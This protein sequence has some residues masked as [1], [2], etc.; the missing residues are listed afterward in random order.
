MRTPCVLLLLM[1]ANVAHASRESPL[2]QE[3]VVSREKMQRIMNLTS[4]TTECVVKEAL[5]FS[6][7]RN[8]DLAD[9]L[10]DKRSPCAAIVRELV[11]AV[12]EVYG[13]GEGDKYLMGYYLDELPQII[14]NRIEKPKK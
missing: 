11:T 13:E 7:R 6:K 14:E 3:E 5:K 2:Q 12:D 1:C 10:I 4:K 9:V 8:I